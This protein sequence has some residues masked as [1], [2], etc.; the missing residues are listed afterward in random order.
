MGHCKPNPEY[1]QDI[2]K[3][4]GLKA[5]EALMIG[6]DIKEDIE[7]TSMLGIDSL[8]IK[9]TAIGNIDEAKVP[10]LS[11]AELFDHIDHYL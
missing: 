11:F 9:D 3:M 5:D 2:L 8:L 6:N 1:Y 7:P 4:T 10:V